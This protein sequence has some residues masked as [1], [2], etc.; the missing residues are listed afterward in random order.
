VHQKEAWEG[1]YN[2]STNLKQFNEY[3]RDHQKDVGNPTTAELKEAAKNTWTAKQAAKY[4][5]TEVHLLSGS[6][7]DNQG[8]HSYMSVEFFRKENL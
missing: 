3:L 4:G 7:H 1:D 5:F 8:N 6:Q 2:S